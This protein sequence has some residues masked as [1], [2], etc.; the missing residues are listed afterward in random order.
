MEALHR[1][2]GDSAVATIFWSRKAPHYKPWSLQV[3]TGHPQHFRCNACAIDQ[4][5]KKH[6]LRK[7]KDKNVYTAE[8]HDVPRI[9]SLRVHLRVFQEKEH[10]R[11][12]LHVCIY[13][14]NAR[15]FKNRAV[16]RGLKVKIYK[17]R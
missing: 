4:N 8:P 6:D 12:H 14:L 7:L 10:S 13:M 17:I 1:K 16:N 5:F 9:S 11:V 15:P 2:A 3:K